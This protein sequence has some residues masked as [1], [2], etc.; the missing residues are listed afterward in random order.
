MKFSLSSDCVVAVSL[1]GPIATEI[2][3]NSDPKI[4][5]KRWD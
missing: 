1:A 3:T 2:G 4:D 5:L